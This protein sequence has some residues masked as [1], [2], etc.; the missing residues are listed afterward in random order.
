MIHVAT[1]IEAKTA[2]ERQQFLNPE[3]TEPRL[4]GAVLALGV[5]VTHVDYPTLV[6]TSV[7]R[8]GGPNYS[9]HTINEERPRTH[10]VDVRAH[11]NRYTPDQES[12][13]REFLRT[14]FWRYDMPYLERTI[15]NWRGICRIHGDGASRH[16]HIAVARLAD[17][18]AHVRFAP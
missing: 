17:E 11:F 9:P 2:L 3:I 18:Q 10:A 15:N 16:M 4:I 12:D 7:A 5:Y 14:H 13:I 1:G 8:Y 6:L